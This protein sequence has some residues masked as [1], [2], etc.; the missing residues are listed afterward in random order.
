LQTDV[1]Q[2]L[3]LI[4]TPVLVPSL[5]AIKRIILEMFGHLGS[6]LPPV[7]YTLPQSSKDHHSRELARYTSVIVIVGSNNYADGFHHYT[8]A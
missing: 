5:R 2:G 6:L 8:G 1:D 3:P 4:T 7:K